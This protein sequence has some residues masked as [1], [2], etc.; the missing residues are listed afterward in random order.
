MNA[1]FSY[2]PALPAVTGWI[3]GILLWWIGSPIWLIIFLGGLGIILMFL[4]RHYIAIGGICITAGWL[5]AMLNTPTPLPKG[6]SDGEMRTWSGKVTDSRIG[7]DTQNL[8]VEIDSVRNEGERM[9]HLP[10]FNIS[11]STY[12]GNKAPQIGE[13]IHF[14]ATIEPIQ[15]G[16]DYPGQIDLSTFY[17][18][19][20]IVGS[21]F[22]NCD[23]IR[24]IGRDN[25]IYTWFADRR[26]N[27]ISLLAHSGLND[28]SFG[29]LS[30]LIV[31]YDDELNPN[32]KENFRATGI[33]HAL[34]LSGFHVGVI[35]IF[36]TIILSPLRLYPKFRWLRLL[37]SIVLLW[38]Y[39]LLTGAPLSVVRASTMCSVYLMSLIIGRSSNS[40]N[41]LCVSVLLILAVS[42]FSL[43]SAG[44]QLSVCA[45]L[46]IL[47]FN[48]ILNPVSE[49]KRLL[50][51][52]V[53][54]F[55]ITI[56]AVLGTMILSICYFHRLPL[57]FIIPNIII[58][59]SLY[60]MMFG[61][62]VIIITAALG[63]SWTFVANLENFIVGSLDSFTEYMANLPFAEVSG[64]HMSN[65]AIIA[66]ILLIVT[67]A[68]ALNINNRKGYF[69]LL[70]VFILTVPVYMF[71]G[72]NHPSKDIH[73]VRNYSSTAFFIRDGST[74]IVVPTCRPENINYV[75]EKLQNEIKQYSS[76]YDINSTIV[77][78][79]NFNTENFKLHNDILSFGNTH[80]AIARNLAADT[81]ETDYLIVGRSYNHKIDK[82]LDH[83]NP[84]IVII[85]RDLNPKRA[86]ELRLICTQKELQY[87]DLRESPYRLLTND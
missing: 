86:G 58:A 45:V 52:I 70:T 75:S 59:L 14:P 72:E 13:I 74:L 39:V 76:F 84:R 49:K 22:V 51:W 62:I 44:L 87:I 17:L 53:S 83:Y 16:S 77:T 29:V 30:A 3:A 82:I 54:L 28:D 34:A 56:S 42:P 63:W 64:I 18:Q 55:S 79:N 48:R 81:I 69:A 5:I 35:I 36:I 25:N 57:L 10:P 19:R 31:G 40:Y 73:I 71:G 1:P 32:I 38:V 37:L 15:T 11:V 21:A 43:F 61:G 26:E 80:I 47:A 24:I 9:I 12:S 66:T 50:Y 78:T 33:A 41:S 7:I 8:Y 20:K 60:L 68:I 6:A 85:G 67:G 4:R 65:T 2:V 27:I 46:G 23:S